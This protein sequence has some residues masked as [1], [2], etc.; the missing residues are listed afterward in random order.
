MVNFQQFIISVHQVYFFYNFVSILF[1]T[2]GYSIESNTFWLHDENTI[3]GL[4]I[5]LHNWLLEFEFNAKK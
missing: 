1:P 2:T 5:G 3:P 4:T